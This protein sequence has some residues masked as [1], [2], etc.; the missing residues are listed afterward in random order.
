MRPPTPSGWRQRVN[1]KLADDKNFHFG[2]KSRG[3]CR[4]IENQMRPG[5][6]L[7]LCKAQFIVP[8]SC[9]FSDNY[10]QAHFLEK[11]IA[12]Y[13]NQE[14]NFCSGAKYV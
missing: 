7:F 6:G 4:N 11:T 14:G 13:Q 12:D 2:R 8:V 1:A 10:W 3:A 5:V 9:G